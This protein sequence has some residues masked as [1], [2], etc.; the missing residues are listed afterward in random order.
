[1]SCSLFAK[2]KNKWTVVQ[3]ECEQHP[4]KVVLDLNDMYLIT[5]KS[6]RKFSKYTFHSKHVP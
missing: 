2:R 6:A 3:S 4:Q 1:M 5:K